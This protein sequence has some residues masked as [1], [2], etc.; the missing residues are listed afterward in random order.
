MTFAPWSWATDATTH[1]ERPCI[2]APLTLR[3]QAVGVLYLDRADEYGDF[4]QEDATVLQE[5]ANQVPIAIELAS[6]LRAREELES[7]LEG[8]E[9]MDAVGRLVGGVAHDFNNVLSSIQLAA[10]NLAQ[11]AGSAAQRSDLNDIVSSAGRGAELA[12]QLLAFAR[13][14]TFATRVITLDRLLE[15]VSALLLR[16]IGEHIELRRLAE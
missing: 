8:A 15:N 4:T 14:H 3:E 1:V 10:D 12:Q 5:L 9:K 16:L 7:Q 11:T 13:Q 2:V 6:A